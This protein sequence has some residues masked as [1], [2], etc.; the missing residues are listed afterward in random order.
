MQNNTLYRSVTAFNYHIKNGYT[1]KVGISFKIVLAS[2]WK[3]VYSK[4]KEFA[5][6]GANSFLLPFSEETCV[7]E[8]KE[9]VTKVVS[10]VKDDR[11]LTKCTCVDQEVG[12]LP[13]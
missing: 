9:E 13:T 3:G 10:H 6:K 4:R 5:P 8:S 7:Q 2:F 11:I 12:L 1:F